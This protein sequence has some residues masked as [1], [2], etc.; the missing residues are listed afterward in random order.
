MNNLV[1]TGRPSGSWATSEQRNPAAYLLCSTK[2]SYTPD[3]L[4]ISIDAQYDIVNEHVPACAAMAALVFHTQ[5]TP[6]LH[7]LRQDSTAVRRL[8]DGRAES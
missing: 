3:A 2:A 7:V 6:A 4:Q 5:L 1:R 8:F